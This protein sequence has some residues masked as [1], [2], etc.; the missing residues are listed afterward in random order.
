VRGARAVVRRP[1]VARARRCSGGGSTSTRRVS[2]RCR[3]KGGDV[4]EHRV[5]AWHEV[6]KAG[7][8]TAFSWRRRCSD[9]LQRS[10]EGPT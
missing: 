10:G 7:G 8:A 6:V 1:T 5:T 2:E 9:G 3:A 4:G